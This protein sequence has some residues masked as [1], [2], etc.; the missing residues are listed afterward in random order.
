MRLYLREVTRVA[1]IKAG[2]PTWFCFGCQ[3]VVPKRTALVGDGKMTCEKFECVSS[4]IL[5]E[6]WKRVAKPVTKGPVMITCTHCK[7]EGKM[8]IKKKLASKT[9]SREQVIAENKA[10]EAQGGIPS[11]YVESLSS[12]ILNGK[13][14]P[15][16]GTVFAKDMVPDTQYA[17]MEST[18]RVCRRIVLNAED[19]AK[20]KDQVMLEFYS[21]GHYGWIRTTVPLMY[22]L[23]S[24]LAS[25]APGQVP[26]N[27][28]ATM[29][30]SKRKHTGAGKVAKPARA[31]ND[32][33]GYKEGTVGDL[34]GK[35]LLEYKSEE[36]IV[37]LVAE[38]VSESFKAKGKSATKE[39]TWARAKHIISVLRKTD[40]KRYPTPEKS[41]KEKPAAKSK[42]KAPK[43]RKE[44]VNA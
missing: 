7:G 3:E 28:E 40:A 44:P 12:R 18:P 34:A 42:A 23:T 8:P 17:N 36:K 10:I 33:T 5:R 16:V 22:P 1:K 11:D 13:T 15:P 19:T 24:D 25:V 37:E 9:K 4:V 14:K 38:Q 29:A 6:E 39:V 26:T 20:Y 43:T 35:V 30:N 41:E 31:M 27:K 21:G 2:A 32:K